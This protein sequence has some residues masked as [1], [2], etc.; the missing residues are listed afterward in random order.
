MNQVLE[1]LLHQRTT[2][3]P[4]SQLVRALWNFPLTKPLKKTAALQGY[5]LEVSET[6]FMYLHLSTKYF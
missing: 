5:Q 2:V 1:G 6:F 3:W 4:N